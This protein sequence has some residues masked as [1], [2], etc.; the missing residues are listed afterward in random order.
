[1][2]TV[3]ESEKRQTKSSS[4][5]WIPS[6]QVRIHCGMPSQPDT[7]PLPNPITPEINPASPIPQL[8]TATSKL[9]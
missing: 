3:T 4:T 7:F 1:M 6:G 2:C 5:T 8:N 9:L